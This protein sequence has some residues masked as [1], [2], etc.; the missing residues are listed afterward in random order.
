MASAALENM[1]HPANP[2]QNSKEPRESR[3]TSLIV[4][5]AG[6]EAGG[7][8]MNST[9]NPGNGW[10]CQPP[11]GQIALAP[12]LK[13]SVV[14]RLN[15]AGLLQRRLLDTI[16]G[17]KRRCGLQAIRRGTTPALRGWRS[18]AVL[19]PPPPPPAL[20]QDASRRRNRAAF[21]ATTTT[22]TATPPTTT[23]QANHRRR[24]RRP[25]LINSH[26]LH[27]P[28]T[29]HEAKMQ[30]SSR[31]RRLC[32]TT[33]PNRSWAPQP[34]HARFGASTMRSVAGAKTTA[35]QAI[36]ARFCESRG[37]Q[38]VRDA[39][40]I[41]PTNCP[42]KAGGRR[43][44]GLLIDRCPAHP[45]RTREEEAVSAA[46]TTDVSLSPLWAALVATMQA[47]SHEPARRACKTSQ[48]GHR[49]EKGLAQAARRATTGASIGV[50]KPIGLHSWRMQYRHIASSHALADERNS[51][52]TA[53]NERY[54]SICLNLRC[55]RRQLKRCNAPDL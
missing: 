1:T 55:P 28:S 44:A 10:P 16:A 50:K 8:A 31:T 40:P 7:G 38:G 30:G 26:M 39:A 21:T 48:Q 15:Q 51:R 12:G 52:K 17:G 14:G 33:P 46:R 37:S 2:A 3:A 4:T 53:P 42:V 41:A 20:T 6:M 47:L 34:R 11:N 24:H 5:S 36:A 23:R 45:K 35:Y 54:A 43:R 49:G 25:S 22:T 19:C 27:R 18:R 32:S 13:S 29:T 9:L